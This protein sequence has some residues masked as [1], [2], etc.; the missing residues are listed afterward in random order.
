[1]ASTIPLI[2]Q[3]R[4]PAGW[5]GR[6]L[7]RIMSARHSKLTDWG[8]AGVAVTAGG[9]M[10]DVGCGGGRTVGKLAALAP[11]G[12]VYGIDYSA[13]SVA[14]SRRANARSIASGRVEIRQGTVSD[15]PFP[16]ETF[17]LITAVETHFYWPDLPA[18]T[19]ELWRVLKPGGTLVLIAE[20]Y[21]ESSKP[22]ARLDTLASVGGMQLLTLDEHRDLLTAAGFASVRVRNDPARLWVC[23][24]GDKPPTPGT[25]AGEAVSPPA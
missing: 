7:L 9:V 2:D 10:L 24:S 12:K 18:D 8:L 13:T 25:S 23:A 21:R 17:D 6:V 22:N 4:K 1:L 11:Q 14:F 3:C 5:L 15:L 20:I 19:R 16:D